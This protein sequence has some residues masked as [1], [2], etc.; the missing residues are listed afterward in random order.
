MWL[1]NTFRGATGS[2]RRRPHIAGFW[3]VGR[4]RLS[5]Q[6]VAV[7]FGTSW[8][9]VFRSVRYAVHW[10]IV[11][12]TWNNVVSIGIDEIAWRKGHKYLTLVY[13]IGE[14]RKRL[15]SIAQERAKAALHRFFDVL[16]PEQRAELKFVVSDMWQNCLEVVRERAGEAVHILDRFHVMKKLNESLDQVRRDET[17]RLKANGYKPVLK[18]TR[19]CLQKR[20]Q[21]LS[22]RQTVTL[23]ELLT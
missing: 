6:E 17:R 14:G 16:Q 20:P 3:Q 9:T 5:C 2:T 11:H 23:K 1:S 15:L 21:N 18:K 8:Q 13:Q 19:W 4:K 12:D 10:G 22:K 7:V